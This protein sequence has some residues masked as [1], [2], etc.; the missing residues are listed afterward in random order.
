MT[1]RIYLSEN[2]IY[3]GKSASSAILEYL[4]ENNVSGATVIR[5]TA[6]YGVHT[7]LH[8]TRILRL[9]S[10]LPQIIEIIEDEEK[11]RPL[12]DCIRSMIPKELIT[13]HRIE[14]LSGERI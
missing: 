3:K 6:G 1:I 9:S 10:D 12:I 13:M 8:T 7:D 14:V 11:I 2:D 5:G 4:K